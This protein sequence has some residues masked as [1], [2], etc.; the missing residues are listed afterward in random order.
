[1]L[2]QTLNQPQKFH[3]FRTRCITSSPDLSLLSKFEKASRTFRV[4]ASA[5][6]NSNSKCRLTKRCHSSDQCSGLASNGKDH[7]LHNMYMQSYN[8]LHDYMYINVCLH[9]SWIFT[10]VDDMI[11]IGYQ[12]HV[13]AFGKYTRM[14]AYG[15]FEHAYMPRYALVF[16]NL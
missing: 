2:F 7:K 15:M 13:Y 6:L 14:K 10:L 8:D 5:R 1:M 4:L 16:K 11:R 12:Y 9:L 3:H